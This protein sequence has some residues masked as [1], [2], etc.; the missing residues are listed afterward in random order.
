[1]DGLP[2]GTIPS[3]TLDEETKREPID[4]TQ[5]VN[6]WL[7]KL[8][9]FLKKKSFDDIPGLFIEDCWWRDIIGLSWDFTSRHG[10][11]AI[12][13]YLAHAVSLPFNL[14]GIKSGG[15]QPA[16][17]DTG[18]MIWVQAGFHLRDSTWCR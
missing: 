6:D 13:D 15:L 17:V 4:P 10:F 8:E 11:A 18:S 12:R 14:Q 7:I 5:L 3:L 2:L 9:E 1:M 16:I